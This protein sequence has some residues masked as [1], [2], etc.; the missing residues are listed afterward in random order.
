MESSVKSSLNGLEEAL[1]RAENKFDE[2]EF[3]VD[4][5]IADVSGSQSNSNTSDLVNSVN[6]IKQEFKEIS[7]EVENLKKIQAE[8][9]NDVLSKLNTI[10]F[11]VERLN[12]EFGQQDQPQQQQQ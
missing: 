2:V 1:K 9:V 4:K 10:A 8:A 5:R 7:Q 3:K 6:K 12:K 11:D